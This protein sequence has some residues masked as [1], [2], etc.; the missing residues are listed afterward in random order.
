K[1][2]IE[3]QLDVK[4][5]NISGLPSS[6]F[7]EFSMSVMKQH[8][9]ILLFFTGAVPLVLSVTRKYY[10]V[11]PGQNWIDAQTYCQANYTDLAIIESDDDMVQLLNE[12]KNQKYLSSAWIGLYSN[13]NS[14]HWSLG[15]Q[16]VGPMRNWE[17]G[18]PNNRGGRQNCAAISLLG[19]SD[20]ACTELHPFICFDDRLSGNNRYIYV[21]NSTQWPDA[22]TYCRHYHT[23]LASSRDAAENSVLMGI[24]NGITWFGMFK[25]GWKWVDNTNMSIISWMYGYPNNNYWNENC[26]YI[27]NGK[28]YDGQCKNILPFFCYTDLKKTQTI[29]MKI[30]STQDLND[31]AINAAIL[32]E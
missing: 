9:F 6:P 2:S 11:Q 30:K 24:I 12:A 18:E 16:P 4:S 27:N 32:E 10:L 26:A 7:R 13:I 28:A 5:Y 21:S 31:P 3:E 29:R 8:L 19:W 17:V 1:V 14:W 20:L 22:Q 15:Y 25:D 23:D